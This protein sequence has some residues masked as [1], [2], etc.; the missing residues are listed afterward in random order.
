MRFLAL[1]TLLIAL[2]SLSLAET[3]DRCGDLVRAW[4]EQAAKET[5]I[6]L[7]PISCG[8]A[9]LRLQVRPSNDEPFD[10]A[11]EPDARTPF[12][13]IGKLGVSPIM[14]VKYET[15]SQARRDAYDKLFEW[16]RNHLDLVRFEVEEAASP[17]TTLRSP[18]GFGLPALGLPILLLAAL[19]LFAQARPT[20]S[21]DDRRDVLITF[22]FALALRLAIGR[23]GPLHVNGQGAM[24]I[25]SAAGLPGLVEPYGPGYVELFRPLGALFATSPDRAIFVANAILSAAIPP[26]A[27]WLARTQGLS[28]G[29]ALIAALLL[30]TDPV[31]ID[32]ATTETYLVPIAAL[33]LA[34]SLSLA[35]ARDRWTNADRR[36]AA[37]LLIAGGL[38]AAQAARIHAASWP[39]LA[40]TPLVLT[41]E[42][43]WLARLAWPVVGALVV[44]GT[45]FALDARW[46]LSIAP[47]AGGRDFVQET[48]WHA[49]Q[50]PDSFRIAAIA[51]PILALVAWRRF[52]WVLAAAPY[53]GLA[54]FL[55]H[56]YNQSAAWEAAYV[57]LFFALPAL[58]LAAALPPRTPAPNRIAWGL[59]LIVATLVSARTRPPDTT[60]QLEYRW[61]RDRLQGLPE[62]CR[63]WSVRRA[64]DALRY[65]PDYV[66]ARGLAGPH[67]PRTAPPDHAELASHCGVYV[68]SSIC[69]L[70]GER[71]GTYERALPPMQAYERVSLPAVQSSKGFPYATSD[72]E[73]VLMRAEP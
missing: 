49:S 21:G 28:R 25:W 13:A 33:A 22:A 63:V 12:R 73:L 19:L 67:L 1:A 35:L 60:E 7:E 38:F 48:M 3:S 18:P 59:T 42:G 2:P 16:I 43:R 17:E 53:V 62:G 46:I 71:C 55:R 66:I 68:R 31:A 4:V 5:S 8:A 47:Q 65:L 50:A 14:N 39:L 23:W 15:V 54:L 58:A 27:F 40:L 36:S 29:P 56:A 61:L 52:T 11:I 44:G 6:A 32:T 41:T 70:K 45:I 20:L 69:S 72:V 10:V 64:D 26:L 24:W 30:A 57:R 37:L 34:T 9:T 51:L